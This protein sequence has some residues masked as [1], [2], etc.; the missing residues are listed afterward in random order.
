M[1]G[2]LVGGRDLNNSLDKW[3][4]KILKGWIDDVAIC[5]ELNL[6]T[7]FGMAKQFQMKKLS[8]TKFYISTRCMTLVRS[9]FY[10]RSYTKVYIKKYIHQLSHIQS[11]EPSS[12]DN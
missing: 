12:L 6:V 4:A 5:C 2:R 9:L 1:R 11:V 3:E 10:M 7:K 8:T